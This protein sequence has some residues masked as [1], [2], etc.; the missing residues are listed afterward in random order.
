[1]TEL[2]CICLLYTSSTPLILVVPYTSEQLRT[3]GSIHFGI[4]SAVRIDVYKRQR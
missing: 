1:M 2:I 4:S 3:S